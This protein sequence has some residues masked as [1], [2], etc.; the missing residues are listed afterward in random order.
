[1]DTNWELIHT[2]KTS[3]FKLVDSILQSIFRTGNLL[4]FSEHMQKDIILMYYRE[5]SYFKNIG[6]TPTGEELK[7]LFPMLYRTLKNLKDEL[8]KEEIKNKPLKTI[9]NKL[10]KTKNRK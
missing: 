5:L 7:K 1:M 4:Y 10:L 9:K 6:V 3:T 2:H 8:H